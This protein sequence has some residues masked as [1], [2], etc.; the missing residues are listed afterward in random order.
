MLFVAYYMNIFYMD[1][2]V[3]DGI[4]AA[5]LVDPSSEQDIA[6]GLISDGLMLVEKRRERKLAKLVSYFLILVS[7]SH[8]QYWVALS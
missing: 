8:R 3:I 2:F 1:I 5:S 6:K 4:A 7:T